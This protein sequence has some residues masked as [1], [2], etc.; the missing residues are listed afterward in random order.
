M[1]FSTENYDLF[2]YLSNY[3]TSLFIYLP[4]SQKIK[5]NEMTDYS[6]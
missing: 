6:D 3:C 4:M 2:I 1:V 5:T